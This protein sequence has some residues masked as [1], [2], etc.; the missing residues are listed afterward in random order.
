[1][2]GEAGIV[3]PAA[4]SSREGGDEVVTWRRRSG[5]LPA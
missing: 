2:R 4:R 5:K 3:E 1:M